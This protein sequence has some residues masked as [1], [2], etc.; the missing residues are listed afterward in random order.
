MDTSSENFSFGQQLIDQATANDTTIY[1]IA[2]GD[3]A[4]EQ[5]LQDLAWR[6]NGNFYLGDQANIS[7]IYGDMSVIFGGSAGIG[8]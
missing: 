7:E 6:A 4:D 8:R 5:I 2:F 1:T 3:D